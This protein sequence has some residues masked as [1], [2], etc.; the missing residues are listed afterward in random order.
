M[1][2]E[3]PP[4]VTLIGSSGLGPISVRTT[5]E[6]LRETL[7]PVAAQTSPMRLRFDPPMR[8]MQSNVVVLPLDPHGP[9]RTLH[10]GMATRIRDAKLV[11]ERARFTFTPHCTLSFYRQLSPATLRE[12]LAVR[13]DDEVTIER[14][15]AYRATNESRTERLFALELTAPS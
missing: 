10:E 15:Q 6:R 13:I 8:F 4:H 5:P 2:D 14:I 7:A 1:A 11:A 3:L 12:I 9:L